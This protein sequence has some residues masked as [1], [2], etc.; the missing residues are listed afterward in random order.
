MTVAEK[1][2]LATRDL[3]PLIGTAI[4]ADKPALLSG[5]HAAAI[6][7]L[8]ERR[9]VLVF[10]QIHFTDEE[11]IAFTRTLGKFAKELRGEEIYKVTLDKGENATAEYL[12]GAF[13][14]HIDGTMSPMPILA[15][16]LSAKR[17]SET[18]GDTEFS[19][20]YAAYEA[21]SEEDKAALEGVKVVHTLAASQK[22]VDPEPTYAKYREWRGM[23]RDVQPLVWTHRSG[24]KS[25]VL[26]ATCD[27]V[28]GMDPL[29]G[30]EL[31]LRLRDF[32]TQ[33]QFVYSHKWTLGDT[34]MWDNTGT[35]HRATEYPLD[36]G[37]MM[38]RT[39]LEG[40]EPVA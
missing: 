5:E 31:L 39:K 23:G 12:K 37:R 2:R 40:E 4:L 35:M 11:Q 9:G 14:W 20:T 19:N 10:P 17:L 24:R 21:L 18:G 6:R 34:V 25:L 27:H 7:E 32:A 3:A 8:L 30:E 1:T 16:I 26:G 36:S 33:P 38:H 29:E 15:S 28:V 22:M 13:F